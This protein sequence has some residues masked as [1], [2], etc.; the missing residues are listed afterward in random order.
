M[1]GAHG[2]HEYVG[3]SNGERETGNEKR[4]RRGVDPSYAASPRLPVGTPAKCLKPWK[5]LKTIT[6]LKSF[7]FPVSGFQLNGNKQQAAS[8]KLELA[9]NTS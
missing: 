9:G 1:E 2:D 6:H 3:L 5:V 8:C 7:Q 4:T